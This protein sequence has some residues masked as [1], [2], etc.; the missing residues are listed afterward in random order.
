MKGI[1]DKWFAYTFRTHICSYT[2]LCLIFFSCF[3]LPTTDCLC[4]LFFFLVWVWTPWISAVHRPRLSM[5][6]TGRTPCCSTCTS[7]WRSSTTFTPQAARQRTPSPWR[8]GWQ[9]GPEKQKAHRFCLCRFISCFI[10]CFK[11]YFKLNQTCICRNKA[12]FIH[13]KAVQL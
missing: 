5:P 9:V 10:K 8:R 11:S 7:R 12:N 4:L 13:S 1:V 3:S 6:S 2:R